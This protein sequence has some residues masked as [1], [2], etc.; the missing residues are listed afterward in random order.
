LSSVIGG[1]ERLGLFRR[2]YL[3]QLF[4]EQEREEKYWAQKTEKPPSAGGIGSLRKTPPK[5][6][7]PSGSKKSG[8][9]RIRR[10]RRGAKISSWL[11]RPRDERRGR[12]CGKRQGRGLV[13]ERAIFPCRGTEIRSGGKGDYSTPEKGKKTTKRLAG[14]L[15]KGG[16]V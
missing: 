2:Q 8:G 9:S 15:Q 1:V 13:E 16:R 10:L 7:A 12:N 6:K 11:S 14:H 3:T 4:G 5:K